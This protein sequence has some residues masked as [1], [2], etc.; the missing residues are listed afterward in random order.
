MFLPCFKP[1]ILLSLNK[2]VWIQLVLYFS[3]VLPHLLFPA[4]IL[5]SHFKV[6]SFNHHTQ[7]LWDFLHCLKNYFLI[8]GL[9]PHCRGIN[10]SEKKK[11]KK[12]KINSTTIYSVVFTVRNGGE[13][14]KDCFSNIST[15][16]IKL[17]FALV[18]ICLSQNLTSCTIFC[19]KYFMGFFFF[20]KTN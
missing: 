7:T 14:I 8:A 16:E 20:L 17:Q 1:V 2:E 9:L 19:L 5:Q 6:K 3:P 15:S 11:K 4:A 10:I 13:A 12:K 18:W